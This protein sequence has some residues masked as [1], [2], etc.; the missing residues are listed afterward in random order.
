MT[1]KI[2]ELF[3]KGVFTTRI[4]TLTLTGICSYLWISGIP[5]DETLKTSWLIIIG[6]YFNTEISQW[7]IKQ[8]IQGKGGEDAK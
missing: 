2:L 4:I 7:I 6:F 8:I 3:G 5:L 1:D